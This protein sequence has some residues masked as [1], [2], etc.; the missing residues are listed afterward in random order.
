VN[1]DPVNS[2]FSNATRAVDIAQARFEE[3]AR[4]IARGEIEAEDMARMIEDERAVE[5]NAASMRV[6]DR[7]V[8]TLIDTVA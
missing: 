2:V 8:G 7:M 3:R 1:V 6:A 5:A 4:E